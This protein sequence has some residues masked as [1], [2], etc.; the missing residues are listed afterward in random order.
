VRRA[1]HLALV[2]SLACLPA[3]SARAER[4]TL[5]EPMP[6]SFA[7]VSGVV[8]PVS[9]AEASGTPICLDIGGCN[10]SFAASDTIFSRV[11]L[12][13]GSAPLHAIGIATNLPPGLPRQEGYLPSGDPTAPIPSGGLTMGS[14]RAFKFLTPQTLDGGE[15]SPVLVTGH[16][17]GRVRTWVNT[18][19]LAEVRG[20]ATPTSISTEIGQVPL[21]SLDGAPPVSLQRMNESF[22]RFQRPVQVT[23]PAGDPRLFVA[24]QVSQS[25]IDG[26]HRASILVRPADAPPATF[27]TTFLTVQVAFDTFDPFDERGLLGLAFAP[28]YATSG[29][30]YVHYVAPDPA[31]PDG[32]GRIT[33]ARHTVSAD[34][35]VANPVGTVL[36]SIPKPGPPAGDPEAFEAY[37]NGGSLAFGP[38]GRLYVGIGDG[39]GWQG[40]DPWNCA[41]N[42]A[43]PL[44]KILRLDPAVLAATPVVVAPAAQCPTLAQ[45]APAGLEIW[46][47]GL[48]NPW[49]FHF[50]RETGDLWI[51]DVGQ[52][53]REEI[54]FVSASA[55]SGPGPNFG[56]DVE[57]G[58]LCNATAPAPSPACGSP[59]LTR[60]L[61]EYAHAF[62]PGGC[63]GS[64]IGGFVHRGPVQA[65][66]GKYLFGDPCQ[67]FLRTLTPTGGGGV[68]AE[69]L[70][71]ELIAQ[72]GFLS[73]FGEDGSGRLY[74]VDFGRGDVYRLVPEPG[75]AAGGLAALG[76]LAGLRRRAWGA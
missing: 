58:T 46:A 59:A 51:G 5:A 33:I 53:E 37:H 6:F 54:D 70:P 56:W 17:L 65:L 57:E 19:T 21:A 62:G 36:L 76:A 24:E 26:T 3:R 49:R 27:P 25:L 9:A 50:D 42:P 14:N 31:A 7:G 8:L 13:A 32:P 20:I 52:I 10:A 47:R 67:G 30:F 39:G 15:S 38:D 69:D 34:P 72:I 28:D 71:G 4:F 29:A 44:G 2:L 61:Y 40:Y 63:S 74:A 60:P 73:S 12:D 41:Q 1:F 16:P 48:R 64:V 43:S 45:P 66:R 11:V 68:V 35:N 75:A 23:A 55:L 18:G 22:T